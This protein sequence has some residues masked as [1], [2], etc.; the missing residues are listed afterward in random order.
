M[1]EGAFSEQM[2]SVAHNVR[3]ALA[4]YTKSGQRLTMQDSAAMRSFLGAPVSMLQ[5][6]HKGAYETQSGAIQG[7]LADMMDSFTRDYAS[8]DEEEKAKQADF[9]ALMKTK[10]D[11]LKALEKALTDKTMNEGDDVKQLATDQKEREET[12]DELKATE[13]FLET[14][15]EAC[16]AKAD[17]WAERSRLRTEE[18]AGMNQAIDILTSDSAKGTFA[19][20]VD[21]FVQLGQQKNLQTK[22]HSTVTRHL[23]SV[24]AAL[25]A[26]TAPQK[27]AEIQTEAKSAHTMKRFEE[28][29]HDI[30]V[31]EDDLR[32]EGLEDIKI[33][34]HCDNERREVNNHQESLEFDMDAL[35]KEMDSGEA[36]KKLLAK[37]IQHTKENEQKLE[38]EMKEY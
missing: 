36:K 5:S 37:Q 32:E 8:N 15:T 16:K 31:M 13:E 25:K 34:A 35:Q 12:E 10:T 33:K 22:S 24:K 19:T 2:R 9:D 38:K 6:P 20:A 7:I 17:E 28:V 18:L 26:E 23:K 1:M 29:Q 3:S 27:V 21:T 14:T 30:D 11:D 4:M